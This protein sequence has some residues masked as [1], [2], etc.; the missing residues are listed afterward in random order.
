MYGPCYSVVRVLRPLR[1]DPV[2]DLNHASTR[3]VM[4]RNCHVTLRVPPLEGRCDV[5]FTINWATYLL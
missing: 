3:A 2:T 1:R 4:A 5:L